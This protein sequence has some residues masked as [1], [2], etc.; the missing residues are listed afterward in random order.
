MAYYLGKWRVRTAYDAE[1]IA[2]P[3]GRLPNPAAHPTSPT[4][5]NSLGSV[6]STLPSPPAPRP[7][8]APARVVAYLGARVPTVAACAVGAN[9][10]HAGEVLAH[11]DIGELPAT[12]RIAVIWIHGSFP[13]AIM[14]TLLGEPTGTSHKF[15][16]EY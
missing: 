13:G 1:K 9:L 14:R 8:R 2:Y 7:R 11:L 6:Y 3:D 15:A 4:S 10:P 5:S 12:R 16:G